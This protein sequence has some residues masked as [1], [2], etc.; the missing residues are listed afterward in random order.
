MLTGM[1]EIDWAIV[2]EVFEGVQSR[3]GE[4]RRDDR[5][6]LKALHFFTVGSPRC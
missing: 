4:P 6:L 5:K 3:R 2:L 1:T